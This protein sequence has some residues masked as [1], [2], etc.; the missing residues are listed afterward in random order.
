[1]YMWV[2][3]ASHQNFV[4]YIDYLT[5]QLHTKALLDY[6][7]RSTYHLN[8]TAKDNDG[9]HSDHVLI[10]IQ[11]IDINDNSPIIE[12]PSSISIPS[13]IFQ[14]NVSETILITKIN[15]NDRDSGANGNLTYA[16]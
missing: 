14:T 16:S 9:L 10:T 5:G 11:L 7:T 6:E 12:T 2:Y 8:I 1:M 15:A 3:D 4:F 13:Q